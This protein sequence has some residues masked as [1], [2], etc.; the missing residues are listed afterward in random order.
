MTFILRISVLNSNCTIEQADS[1]YTFGT[2]YPKVQH[3]E[4]LGECIVCEDGKSGKQFLEEILINGDVES[5]DGKSNLGRKMKKLK[6]RSYTIVYDRSGIN[7]D[8]ET[9]LEFCKAKNIC[10]VSEIDWD[11]FETYILESPEYHISV[12]GYPNKET[13]ANQVM[14]ETFPGYDKSALPVEM[15]RPVYWKVEEAVSL[16]KKE[17]SQL[18]I[19]QINVF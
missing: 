17:K 19:A 15:K 2:V 16:L 8:Y 13:A 10:V 6:K 1:R 7:T 14:Y 5:A 4:E 11:S 18:S 3:L 12:S 9:M